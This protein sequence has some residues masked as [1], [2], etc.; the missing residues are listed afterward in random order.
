MVSQVVFPVAGFHAPW[1]GIAYAYPVAETFGAAQEG[2]KRKRKGVVMF[3]MPNTGEAGDKECVTCHRPL[4]EL[5][6]DT[7]NDKP[8]NQSNWNYHAATK[9]VFGGQH[10]ICSWTSLLNMVSALS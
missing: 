2:M 6:A 4:K 8:D 3:K 9:T 5:A 7:T 1:T 10:Y